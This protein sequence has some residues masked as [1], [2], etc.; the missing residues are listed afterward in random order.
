[1]ADLRCGECI[2]GA[3]VKRLQRGN[4]GRVTG[5][6]WKET[7]GNRMPTI[8]SFQSEAAPMSRAAMMGFVRFD[9]AM[10]QRGESH[11]SV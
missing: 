3:T 10:C 6:M 9:I 4:R 8:G 1:M 7:T 11:T 5:A 2:C